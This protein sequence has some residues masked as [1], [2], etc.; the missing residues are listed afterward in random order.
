MGAST[1]LARHLRLVADLLDPVKAQVTASADPAEVVHSLDLADLL[2]G[3]VG[4]G[5]HVQIVA[6]LLDID[7]R[8]LEVTACLV[9]NVDAT[10]T[11]LALAQS[12]GVA[13]DAVR[14]VYEGDARA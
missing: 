14:R 5:D 7:R 4:L 8:L 1:V 6:H 13:A 12:V 10:E 9:P 11:L 3:F 2:T